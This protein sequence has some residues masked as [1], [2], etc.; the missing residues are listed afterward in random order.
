MWQP[1]QRERK[2]EREI[3]REMQSHCFVGFEDRGKD[4]EPRNA[5]YA[6]IEAGKVISLWRECSLANTRF[7]ARES[8]FRL[9]TSRNVREKMSTVLTHC[10]CKLLHFSCVQLFATP[11]EPTRLLCPWDSPEKNTGVGCRALLQGIFLTQGLNPHLYVSCIN[12]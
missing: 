2:R 12:S 1:L 8:D 11:E 3:E 4:H 5:S 10:A 6:T 7:G 9:V